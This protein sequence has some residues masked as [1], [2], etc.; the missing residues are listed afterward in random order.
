ML[1]VIPVVL[2]LLT[3]ALLAA[4]SRAIPSRLSQWMAMATTLGT[5]GASLYLM[6]ASAVEPIVYWF[7]GW[8]PR[9]GVALGISFTI[10]PLGAGFA[11]FAALLTLAAFVFSSQY[12]DA[13]GNHFHALVLAFL[14][15]MC[16]FTL[17]GD[18]FNLFVFFELMSAAAFALCGYKTDDPASL[19]G[20]LN[21]AVINTI[22][23]Y[24]VLT[25][26]G[27]IY[28]RTA[29]LNMAQAGRALADSPLTGPVL[30][31]FVFL[32]CGYLVKAAVFPF[33]FWLA[34]AHAVAPTPVCLLFSGVMVEMGLFAL[35]RIYWTTFDPALHARR[36]ALTTLFVTI[37]IVTAGVGAFMCYVQP[38]L[39]RLLAFSTI[40]HVGLMLIGIGVFAPEGL[41]GAAIYTLGHGLVKG[42]LFLIAGI[43]LHRFE[44]MDERDLYGKAGRERWTALVFFAGAFGLAGLPFSG[45]AAGHDLMM[46]SVENAGYG[47]IRWVFTIAGAVTGAAVLRAGG[48]IFF[49]W[50]SVEQPDS[51][52]PQ[53]ERPETEGGHDEIPATMFLPATV[54]MA[55]GLLL[56]LVPALE[57]AAAGAARQFENSRGYAAH[58]LDAAPLA[59]ESR[60]ER[61]APSETLPTLLSVLGA[62]AIAGGHLTSHR[63]RHIAGRLTSPL[64]LVHK[65]H[66]GHVGDY[67]V[68]L[69]LGMACFALVCVYCVR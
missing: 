54:L 28:A 67:V 17:S 40:S 39:K 5:L 63:F 36:A 48:H 42:A 68:F 27:L 53:E 8:R 61:E 19:Q 21:F 62:L 57:P 49:G 35:A 33:H 56:G 11:A 9:H 52:P 18:L 12:F 51:G 3:A 55:A 43:L 2:P 46:V 14:G 23:A 38:N 13:V 50:G 22:A 7:G 15:A 34:D 59:G 29:A 64:K 25:G 66:S 30:I 37:G 6:R 47:W 31:G 45:V 58:V 65:I 44:K 1:P 32:V 60:T 69:M 10:D 26:I 16:G 4:L 41:G 24:F 20:A